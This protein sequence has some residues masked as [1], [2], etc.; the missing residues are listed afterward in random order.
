MSTA[1][2]DRVTLDRRVPPLGGFNL[3]YLGIELKRRL[4][5]RRTLFFTV[6]FPVVMFVL[7]GLPLRD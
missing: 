3:T 1:S 4:R 7:I 5:N 2:I 6:A